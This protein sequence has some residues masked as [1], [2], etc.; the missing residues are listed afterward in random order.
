MKRIRISAAAAADLQ[1]VSNYTKKTWGKVRRNLYI[2]Q[3]KQCITLLSSNPQ[4]G[5]V[6]PAPLSRYRKFRH[7]SHL[8]IYRS[9]EDALYIVRILHKS[10][11]VP[12]HIR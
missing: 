4:V 11:D 7:A 2:G 6:L 3:L 8:I 5:T 10:M 12:R 1:S 9:E